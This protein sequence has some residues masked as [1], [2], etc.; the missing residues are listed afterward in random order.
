MKK[1]V[2]VNLNGRVFTMDEDAYH[3]LD[4]YLHNLRIYFRKE[5]GASEIIAD[6]ESRIEELLSE[7]L[8]LGYEV[9][10]LTEVEEVIAR[11]GQPDDFFDAKVDVEENRREDSG[12]VFETQKKKKL[13]R[14]TD[15]KMFGG[16][17]S[18]I[19]AYFGWDILAVRIIGV[20]LIFAT[21][22][23]IVPFYL[24]AWLLFP[25]A[26]TA[27]EKL[28]MRGRPIT[29]ENIGKTVAAEAERKEAP[30][31]RGCLAG[32]LDFFVG[33]IKVCLIGLGILIALPVL[34][35]LFILLVVLFA[36]LVGV[37]GGLLGLPFALAD[38]PSFIIVDNPLLV[39][40]VMIILI[41]LPVV[42]LLY[43]I[44]AY[45]AKLK[46]LHKS[47][48]WGCF[49]VWLLALILFLT[50]GFH[51]DRHKLFDYSNWKVEINDES[52]VIMG[53]G[54]LAEAEYVLH[55]PFESVSLENRLWLSLQIE[56]VPGDSSLILI[57]GD[58]NLIDKIKYQVRDGQ[59]IL[60]THNNVRLKSDNN[61]IVRIQTPDLKKINSKMLG[62]IHIPGNFSADFLDL[63]LE[64]AGR[65]QADKLDVGQLK[66]KSKGI[67]SAILMG[68]ARRADLFLEGAGEIDGFELRADSVITHVEG[69]G[70]VRCDPI[71]YL[72]ANLKGIGSISYRSEPQEKVSEF[73]GL[74]KIGKE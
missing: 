48:K 10:S 19:A 20:V 66:V 70:S 61:L 26:K 8:R 28:Q 55:T 53:N 41:G 42:A 56:Q 32:F 68:K 64:G 69:I 6:F 49:F 38:T 62:N 51:F 13:F 16:V 44:V 47:V 21:Q 17:C 43:A 15:D 11:V 1:T 58:E 3:L 74:G 59:L 25:A 27:E 57:N 9:I 12:K 7:K 65:F 52:A 33:F 30:Q 31:N 40:I 73:A 2:T 39:S 29:V 36:V 71:E 5:E 54:E 60:S 34:F 37:G 72:N 24:L 46:P 18:G 63:E 50:S 35:T 67:G 4:N 23:I 14:D 22:L 45:F